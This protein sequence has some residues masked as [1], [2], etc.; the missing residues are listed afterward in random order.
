MPEVEDQHHARL[1][2]VVDRLVH[3]RVVE[4]QALALVPGARLAGDR[5]RAAGSRNPQRQV[6]GQATVDDAGVRWNVGV[7]AQH[8]EQRLGRVSWN[9]QQRQCFQR[10]GGLRAAFAVRVDAGAVAEEVETRP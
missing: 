7:R 5:K 1:P 2:A 8:R 4:D 3:E 9:A 6:Y 10:G